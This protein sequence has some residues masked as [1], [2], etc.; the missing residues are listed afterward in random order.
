MF[1]ELIFTRQKPDSAWQK[2][3]ATSYGRFFSSS[4]SVASH[5]QHDVH[6]GLLDGLEREVGLAQEDALAHD[7]AVLDAEVDE[8]GG[9]VDEVGGKDHVEC[10]VESE[11]V[12][13]F[14]L[15]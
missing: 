15:T 9:G 11:S 8:A 7:A 6:V 3:L 13:S 12:E 5:L 2:Y 4:L 14:L 10:L 1:K